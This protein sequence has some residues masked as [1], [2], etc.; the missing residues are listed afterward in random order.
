MLSFSLLY[1]DSMILI[2]LYILLVVLHSCM[3]SICLMRI[4]IL[5]PSTVNDNG[6]H[7]IPFI[8]TTEYTFPD[9]FIPQSFVVPF[10]NIFCKAC[11]WEYSIKQHQKPFYRQH[12]G[13]FCLSSI[14]RTSGGSLKSLAL[15]FLAKSMLAVA[16][17][18]PQL[19]SFSLLLWLLCSCSSLCSFASSTLRSSPLR[20]L[21]AVCRMQLS[22][23]WS[24]ICALWLEFPFFPHFPKYFKG[25]LSLEKTY[26]FILCL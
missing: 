25:F 20:T 26:A 13:I 1:F 24:V 3:S 16:Q 10:R 19:P 21:F 22:F 17:L 15:F 8:F 12:P 14:H 7:S 5:C 9:C 2:L 23:P 4:F 18:Y 11:L 6:L